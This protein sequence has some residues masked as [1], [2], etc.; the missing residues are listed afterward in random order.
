MKKVLIIFSLLASS[1]TVNAILT[2]AE[3]R[4]LSLSLLRPEIRNETYLFNLQE[5]PDEDSLIGRYDFRESSFDFALLNYSSFSTAL[6]SFL[7]DRE[8]RGSFLEYTVVDEKISGRLQVSLLAGA[9][10][11][12]DLDEQYIHLYRGVQLRGNIFNRLVFWGYWWS[13]RFQGDLDFAE[14]SSPLI[15]GF[16]KSHHTQSEYTN[17][18]KISGNISYLFDFGKVSLGRGTHLA[19]DNIGGST[20][21]NDAANDYG[22]FG[23]EVYFGKLTLSFLHATLIPD[24]LATVEAYD[25]QDKFLVLHQIS[26]E[27]TPRLKLYFGEQIIYGNR[28]IDPSY[29]LPHIFYRITEHN[30][31]DRDNVLI[32]AGMRWTLFDFAAMYGSLILDELRKSEIFG[33]WWGNK[34][35]LQGGVSFSYAPGLLK[36]DNDKIRT[37]FELTAVRPWMYT[38]KGMITTFSHDGIGLGF[39]E[40]SNL[41]QAAG[42]LIFPI[43]PNL[44]FNQTVSFTKQG[45][46]GNHFS[47]NY[48]DRPSDTAKWLQGRKTDIWRGRSVLTWSLLAHHQLR[49]GMELYRE[50]DNDWQKDLVFGYQVLY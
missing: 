17:L 34:Y 46:V 23:T 33:D 3:N 21:L 27:P 22:Y 31:Q 10:Y 6:R 36:R 30:L 40:G 7:S 39:P 8:R 15:K 16:Y 37:T 1:L 42:E 41:L 44:R 49:L 19:G 5:E 13:G 28:S 48:N 26:Y 11:H 50:N 20:I 4:Y 18:N 2:E 43:L 45:S 32:Y 35:A 12:T 38:H 25:F 14:T 47:I 9:D 29:L 24:T